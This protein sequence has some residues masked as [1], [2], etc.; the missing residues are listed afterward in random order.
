MGSV[1]FDSLLEMLKNLKSL[2]SKEARSELEESLGR[3]LTEEEEFKLLV[4]R[5]RVTLMIR[6][7]GARKGDV[8]YFPFRRSESDEI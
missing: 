8:L 3:E 4:A 6:A 2:S 5:R 7:D 1:S